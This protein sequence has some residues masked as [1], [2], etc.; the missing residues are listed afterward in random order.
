MHVP[1]HFISEDQKHLLHA[2]PVLRVFVQITSCTHHFFTSSFVLFSL[3]FSLPTRPA[4][5]ASPWDVILIFV[6]TSRR[7]PYT[8]RALLRAP[9]VVSTKCIN[10]IE[11]VR[12]ELELLV[13]WTGINL[14]VESHKNIGFQYKDN[15]LSNYA[16]DNFTN[17][18]WLHIRAS[19]KRCQSTARPGI[20]Q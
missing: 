13:E 19:I 3:D 2:L 17:A 15:Q 6:Y 16:S 11:G 4:R 5:Y 12:Y 18:Y 7:Y 1:C 8:L 14:M 9:V 10:R 20:C